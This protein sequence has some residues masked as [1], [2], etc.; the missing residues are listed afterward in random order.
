MTA[1]AKA[2]FQLPVYFTP[3]LNDS[4]KIAGM[5]QAMV[6]SFVSLA[7]QDA[8][9]GEKLFTAD[10][11]SAVA[12]S[13]DWNTQTDGRIVYKTVE[14]LGM[15]ANDKSLPEQVRAAAVVMMTDIAVKDT[16]TNGDIINS[17]LDQMTPANDG[18]LGNFLKPDWKLRSNVVDMDA[19]GSA[20]TNA[21]LRLMSDPRTARHIHAWALEESIFW[22]ANSSIATAQKKVDAWHCWQENSADR[23]GVTYLIQK[24]AALHDHYDGRIDGL[25][26]RYADTANEMMVLNGFDMYELM[27]DNGKR[28]NSPAAKRMDFRRLS[29]EYRHDRAA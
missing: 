22:G 13:E 1:N 23:E 25:T 12:A 26:E 15:M 17:A 29:L 2:T 6:N 11:I 28:V 24:V 27:L 8:D 5:K 21:T 19:A 20:K 10:V 14:A 16:H 3:D 9:K 18:P 7:D 4:P